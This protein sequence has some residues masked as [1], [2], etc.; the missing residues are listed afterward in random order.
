MAKDIMG[1]I[2][3]NES[4]HVVSVLGP[5]RGDRHLLGVHRQAREGLTVRLPILALGLLL[6]PAAVT[7]R[8]RFDAD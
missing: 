2:N 3:G 1:A 4:M 7:A 6:I 8:D 5:Q